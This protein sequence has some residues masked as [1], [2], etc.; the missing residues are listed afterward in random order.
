M[1]INFF[2]LTG[3]TSS[4]AVTFGLCDDPSPAANPA[5][6]DE[7]DTNKWIGEVSNPTLKNADFYAID[8]CVE[9]L[10]PNG[11]QESRCDGMLHY[12]NT[13]T[14]VE[15]K[16]RTFR[17]WLGKACDQLTI[18]VG[19]FHANHDITA[20]DQVDAYVCNKQRPFFKSGF[21]NVIQRFKDDT[22]LILTVQKEIA[23]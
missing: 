17:G 7:T 19:V 4:S 6:I 18:T 10:R 8:H 5:Y 21:S 11:E 12:D 1:A 22:G 14:F 20:Y 16:D 13:L 2:D 23:I 9:I 3:K 15:L